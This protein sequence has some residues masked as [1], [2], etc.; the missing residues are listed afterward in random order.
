M[1]SLSGGTFGIKINDLNFAEDVV[2]I[3]EENVITAPLQL[4]KLGIKNLTCG[5][6]CQIQGINMGEWISNSAFAFGNYTIQGTVEF[7]NASIFEDVV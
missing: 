4:T 7:H 2:R 5:N 3:D 1:L 6:Q